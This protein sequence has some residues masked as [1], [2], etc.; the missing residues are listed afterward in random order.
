MGPQMLDKRRSTGRSIHSND[1]VANAYDMSASN[2]GSWN[3]DTTSATVETGETNNYLG[4]PHSTV[5]FKWTAYADGQLI[6]DSCGTS[7]ESSFVGYRIDDI[8][9]PWNT[10]LM[11]AASLLRTDC[12]NNL[13]VSVDTGQ[14]RYF[15]LDG[16]SGTDFGPA[17]VNWTFTVPN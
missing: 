4:A 2:T 17:Q 11:F 5:W 8:I 7:F 15:Q 12:S 13:Q 16:Y 10:D 3:N 6:V 1:D 14:T 9:D